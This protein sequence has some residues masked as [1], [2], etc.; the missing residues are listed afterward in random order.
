MIEFA[1][2]AATAACA[3]S[4]GTLIECR[5]SGAIRERSV[6]PTAAIAFLCADAEA[7]GTNLTR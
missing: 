7:N 4:L 6:A 1:F 5:F 3:P 2:S